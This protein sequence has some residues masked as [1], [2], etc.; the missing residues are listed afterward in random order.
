MY[1]IATLTILNST[2][3]LNVIILVNQ[4]TA[5]LLELKTT[6]LTNNFLHLNIDNTQVVLF[7]L[8][9]LTLAQLVWALLSQ[10]KYMTLKIW[11][12]YLGAFILFRLYGLYYCI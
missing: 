5:C 8:T 3:H 12:L 1:H 11:I 6:R 7:G 4:L 9:K 10:I 2:Y